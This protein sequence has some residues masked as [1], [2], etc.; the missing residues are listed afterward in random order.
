MLTYISFLVTNGRQSCIRLF[1]RCEKLLGESFGESW[2]LGGKIPGLALSS[3]R[4]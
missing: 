3:F 4:S 1:Q 2:L